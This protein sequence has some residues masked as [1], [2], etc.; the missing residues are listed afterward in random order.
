MYS[1]FL[2]PGMSSPDVTLT[3]MLTQAFRDN[4]QMLGIY[5]DKL[6]N[7]GLILMIA[8]DYILSVTSHIN[9]IIYVG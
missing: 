6:L 4:I 2:K 9:C 8:A 3:V 5:L 7:L 1:T